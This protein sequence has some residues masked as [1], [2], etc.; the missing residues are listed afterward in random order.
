MP[1]ILAPVVGAKTVT[2]LVMV[3]TG[4]K[5]ETAKESGLSHFLEHMFFKGTERRPSTLTIS[6]E[7][8]VL[9]GEYN[10]FTSKEYTGYYVKV[11]AG[12]LGMAL[13]ILGDM[14]TG[15]K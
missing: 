2:A 13:D 10:A 9:G 11:A 3:K 6:A 8:D 14:L 15:S 7:L 5:Y 12:K 4:S 1:L